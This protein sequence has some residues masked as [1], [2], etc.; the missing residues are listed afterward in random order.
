M[1][2]E[3]LVAETLS[4]EMIDAGKRLLNSLDPQMPVD[5][6]FWFLPPKSST[7]RLVLATPAVRIDGPKAVYRKLQGLLKKNQLGPTLSIN[8]ISLI[9]TTDPLVAL[10]R[11]ANKTTREVTGIRFTGNTINGV[12]IPDAYI[13]RIA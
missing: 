6:A 9:D 11:I 12:F 10:F 13:Y 2:E 1:A 3:T 5:A 7:W 4:S 8:N